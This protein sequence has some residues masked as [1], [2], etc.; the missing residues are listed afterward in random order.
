MF[1]VPSS[2]SQHNR[3]NKFQ[4][5]FRKL[6]VLGILCLFQVLELEA[7]LERLTNEYQKAIE[8]KMRCQREADETTKTIQLA[9][10]EPH[11][12]FLLILTT[13]LTAGRLFCR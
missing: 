7:T 9:N 3:S 11:C 6:K 13:H 12:F 10:S 1:Q 4:S 5:H 8:E 2:H